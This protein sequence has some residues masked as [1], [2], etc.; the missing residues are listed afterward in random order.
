MNY[1]FELLDKERLALESAIP[2][3]TSLE[4]KAALIGNKNAVV[5]AMKLLQKCEHH[6][7][8]PS[9]RFTTLPTQQ[10][11]TPS[12]EYRIVEDGETDDPQ[13][14]QEVRIDGGGQVRLHEDDVV[15]EI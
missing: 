8:K 1:V 2:T 12:S 7:I 15:I 6:G 3:A 5:Y 4:D 10:C 9:S 13:Y 14:W 11:R